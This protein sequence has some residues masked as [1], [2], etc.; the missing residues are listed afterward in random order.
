MHSYLS[1]QKSRLSN[2]P[3]VEQLINTADEAVE[4]KESSEDK[5]HAGDLRMRNKGKTP[6][7]ESCGEANEACNS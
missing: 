2:S 1:L 7:R 3:I 4:M 5:G 6:E